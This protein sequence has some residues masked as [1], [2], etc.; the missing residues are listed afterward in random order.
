MHNVHTP[1]TFI[2]TTTLK[3][4]VCLCLLLFVSQQS[5]ASNS[6]LKYTV[7][8]F[9][10]DSI[11]VIDMDYTYTPSLNQPALPDTLYDVVV[12]FTL[13]DSI[14]NVKKIKINLQKHGE[15]NAIT[16]HLINA[17][18]ID[19]LPSNLPNGAYYKKYANEEVEVKMGSYYQSQLPMQTIKFEI[20]IENIKDKSM[21]KVKYKK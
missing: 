1:Y 9:L 7:D 20:E 14:K 11:T 3:I 15:E 18:S 12:K 6:T 21:P 10:V 13:T 19:F 5:K 4:I 16:T 8:T 17:N 2:H